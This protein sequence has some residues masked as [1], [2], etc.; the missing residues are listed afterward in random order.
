MSFLLFIHLS[1]HF[2]FT[3][4]IKVISECHT[5]HASMLEDQHVC[6]VKQGSCSSLLS[7]GWWWWHNVWLELS[8]FLLLKPRSSMSQITMQEQSGVGSV[9]CGGI[10][11]PAAIFVCVQW[12][13]C[14]VSLVTQTDMLLTESHAFWC[15]SD[16]F[17]HKKT[18]LSGCTLSAVWDCEIR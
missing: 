8:T 3:S 18:V 2:L 5:V 15:Y 9:C 10:P 6:N 14:I 16:L 1:I 11:L 4:Y 17:F 13:C 12:Y 7:R